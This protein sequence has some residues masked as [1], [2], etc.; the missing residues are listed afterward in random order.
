MAAPAASFSFHDNRLCPV[1][2]S[3]RSGD[4][5][6]RGNRPHQILLRSPG[7]SRTQA[8][9][10]E[11]RKTLP[12]MALPGSGS[13]ATSGAGGG[14]W[15]GPGPGAAPR[16][17]GGFRSGHDWKL[18][19]WNYQK[20]VGQLNKEL[21]KRNKEK[22]R[23]YNLTIYTVVFLMHRPHGIGVSK[24]A[25]KEIQWKAKFRCYVFDFELITKSTASRWL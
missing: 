5:C 9:V 2:V 20:A 21:G 25:F 10:W 13:R 17:R 11:W 22:Q 23:I 16:P 19:P 14:T 18:H 12:V 24:N 8:R 4:V 7:S 15:P 6:P 1:S 3:E